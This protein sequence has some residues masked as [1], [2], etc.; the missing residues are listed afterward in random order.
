MKFQDT[1]PL[2]DDLLVRKITAFK[3]MD[4]L[5]NA[6]GGYRPSLTKKDEETQRLADSYDAYQEARGDSRRA[7]RG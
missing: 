4:D 5:L 6:K 3:S 7:F 1:T 2:N